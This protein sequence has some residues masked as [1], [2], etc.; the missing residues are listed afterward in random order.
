M[1]PEDWQRVKPILD[2]A[3]QM[4]FT[5]RPAFLKEACA[6][7][8]LRHEIESLIAAHEQ[9]GTGAAEFHGPL[10]RNP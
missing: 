10:A 5:Q 9:A 6:D 8:A 3:L 7:A 4:D 2:S 1:T